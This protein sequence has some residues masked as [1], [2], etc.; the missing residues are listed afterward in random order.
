[1]S[2][3]YVAA[4]LIGASV[5]LGLIIAF[6]VPPILR[7]SRIASRARRDYEQA[8]GT[9]HLRQ[10][11]D[12]RRALDDRLGRLEV[13]KAKLKLDMQDMPAQRD[14]ELSQALCS[15]I[16]HNHLTD[17]SGI[18]PTL[19]DSIIALCFDGTL[20]S[21][22]RA[23]RVHGVGDTKVWAIRGWVYEWTERLPQLMRQNFPKKRSI[24]EEYDAKEHDASKR[25]VDLQEEIDSMKQ[26]RQLAMAEEQ[27]LGKVTVEHFRK[28]YKQDGDA[29]R[30]V[31]EYL[32]GAFKEWETVPAWFAELISEYGA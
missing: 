24:N 31:D 11:R 3:G 5:L 17:I 23:D 8:R 1:M 21:L 15:H 13:D 27:R 9:Q 7:Q 18:G 14:R 20:E 2:A 28:A 19:R 6:A 30:A 10:I 29:S 12:S 25:L 16:V 26:L 4:I 32:E 22:C